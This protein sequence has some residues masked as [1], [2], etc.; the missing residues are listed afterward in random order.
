M[1]LRKYEQYL[2][3]FGV[4]ALVAALLCLAYTQ[5]KL[6]DATSTYTKVQQNSSYT[7]KEQKQLTQIFDFWADMHNEK[8][9]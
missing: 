1:I 5:D 9:N 7:E 3:T 4:A 8:V 2:L 6:N